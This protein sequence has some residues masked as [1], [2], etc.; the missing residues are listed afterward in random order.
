MSGSCGSPGGQEAA[1]A[2]LSADERRAVGGWRIAVERRHRWMATTRAVKTMTTRE[3]KK[4]RAMRARATR[5][6]TEASL[7][8]E[9][10][11]GHNNQLVLSFFLLYQYNMLYRS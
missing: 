10:E 4:A 7:R 6:M 9:G 1:A 11:D 3:T 8:E 5:A 2:P